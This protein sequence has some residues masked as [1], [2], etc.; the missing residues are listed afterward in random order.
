MEGGRGNQS[1]GNMYFLVVIRLAS[2]S[3]LSRMSL[4]LEFALLRLSQRNRGKE[5]EKGGDGK[6]M[7]EEGTRDRNERKSEKRETKREGKREK[8]KKRKKARTQ[9]NISIVVNNTHQLTKSYG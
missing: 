2:F 6:R 7:E 9:G 1:V 3:F 5:K 4:R 8:E